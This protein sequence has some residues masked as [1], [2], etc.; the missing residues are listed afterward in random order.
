M[1]EA[2]GSPSMRAW[3]VRRGLKGRERSLCSRGEEPPGALNSS[4]SAGTLAVVRQA[5]DPSG[6]CFVSNGIV[7]C[8]GVAALAELLRGRRP[9]LG[10][11][12]LLLRWAARLP[13]A[14]SE[15]ARVRRSECRSPFLNRRSV[16]RGVACRRLRRLRRRDA[17]GASAT[18]AVAQ[19]RYRQAPS[20][21]REP[22]IK[23]GGGEQ[24][25][26]TREL[27]LPSRRR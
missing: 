9:A 2:C 3:C 1:Q 12:R 26:R 6:C 14:A 7:S 16:C 13:A 17:V 11:G 15:Q 25:Y 24:A 18:R 19:I 4:G 21:Y 20:A 10:P 27:P 22:S 23:S 8:V 5:L